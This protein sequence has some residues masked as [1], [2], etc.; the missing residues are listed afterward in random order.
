MSSGVELL[1]RFLIVPR[2][3]GF[4]GISER[5]GASGAGIVYIS[6]RF[7]A[8]GAEPGWP[9]VAQISYFLLIASASRAGS[10]SGIELLISYCH[11]F[12]LPGGVYDKL[13][14]LLVVTLLMCFCSCCTALVASC[15]C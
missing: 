4:G 6:E 3:A 11:V 2:E 5:F 7:G 1:K 13:I 14:L 9:R 15:T 10:G 8:S 12:L